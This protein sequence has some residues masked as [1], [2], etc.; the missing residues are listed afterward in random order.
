M[1][2][3]TRVI[4]LVSSL[5]EEQAEILLKLIN[6]L[7]AEELRT[8]EQIKADE[9]ADLARR[10]QA[11]EHLNQMIKEY[12]PLFADIGDNDKEMRLKY[13]DEKYGEGL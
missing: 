8:P 5:T 6:G 2:T 11:F 13:L 4:N 1:S 10:R 12:A 7:D 3:K 9:D